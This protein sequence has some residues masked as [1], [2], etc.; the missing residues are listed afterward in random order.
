MHRKSVDVWVGLFVLLGLAALVA[1]GLLV[2][3]APVKILIGSLV[4]AALVWAAWR[5][6]APRPPERR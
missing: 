3:S 2:V 4:V 6:F 5:A 1:C